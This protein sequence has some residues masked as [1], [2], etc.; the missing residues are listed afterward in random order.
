MPVPPDTLPRLPSRAAGLSR[1]GALQSGVAATLAASRVLAPSLFVGCS[2][3]IPPRA[4]TVRIGLLHSQTGPLAIGSTSLRDVELDAV[5]RFNAA[6]GVLGYHIDPR[7]PDPR[8]RTELFPVRA[9]TLLD[10]G[11]VALFGCWSSASRKAVLP[12]LKER[13]RLL[14]Y[15]VQYEGNETSRNV[16]YGGQVPNQQVLPAL[17]WLRSGPGGERKKFFLLGSDYVYPRTTNFIVRKWLA[18]TDATIVGEEYLPFDQVDFAPVVARIGDSGAD[19][20]LNTV[21]GAANIA[22]FAALARAGVDRA[23]VAVVS[24]SLSEDDLRNMPAAD[25]AGHWLLSSY[26]QTVDTPANA[27]WMAGFRREFGQERVFG[28]SMEAAWCLIQLWKAAVEKAGSFAT[29]A[30]RQVFA[31]GIGFDGPGGKMTID[32]ATQHATKYFRLG[33]VRPDR[34]CDVVVS[35]DGPL[36]PDPYPQ[37]AFPGWKCDWTKGGLQPGPEVSIDG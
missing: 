2:L 13:D 12:L 14:F 36:A 24:T 7:A 25:S 30:V 1:R 23:K 20:I 31:G 33:R 16:I 29:E 10:D 26:F 15:P 19:C 21:N 32:P 34:L 22:L 11:A 35:S 28:D 8:S 5:E 37:I 4:P 3:G 27:A 17:D 9:A 6:G 18:L